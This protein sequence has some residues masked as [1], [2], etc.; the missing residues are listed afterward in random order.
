MM[1]LTFVRA[2]P[3]SSLRNVSCSGMR[4][5]RVKAVG[6]VMC[7]LAGAG[8]VRGAQKKA[9]PVK[10]A[11]EYAAFDTHPNEHVTVAAEPCEETKDCPFFR[12]PYVQHGFVPVRV[13]FTNDSDQAIALDD[14]RIQFIS[15]NKDVIPAATDD[16][17]ER[18]LFTFKSVAG[19]TIPLP[20]PLPSIHTKGKG[21]N[22]QILADDTD[23]G[24]A[25]TTVNAHQTM[26]GYL[27]YDVRGLDDP[28]LKHAEI[29]V[30]MMHTA[31]G[32]QIFAFTVPFD[33]W[34]AARDRAGKTDGAATP[35]AAPGAKLAR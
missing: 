24:F 29:Y 8:P 19:K 22:R 21:I 33:S 28:V 6:L 13:V 2:L 1:I 27:F 15:A 26:G 20:A 3:E 9:P 18:R 25:G 7:L 5:F 4:D 17:L 23:F 34:L 32:K 11:T 31:D 10:A 12:L 14:A 35:A 16:D 30:K